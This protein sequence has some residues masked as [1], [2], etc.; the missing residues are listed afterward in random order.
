MPDPRLIRATL[1]TELGDSEEGDEAEARD[2][3]YLNRVKEG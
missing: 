2:D 1:G 3:Q